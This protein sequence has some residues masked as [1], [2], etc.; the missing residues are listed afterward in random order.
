MF[1]GEGD[2][3]TDITFSHN[4]NFFLF[5]TLENARPIAKGRVPVQPSTFPV[6]TGS[7][8]A[9]MAYL[10]RPSPAG[11]FIFPDLSVRHE[12]LYRLAFS[13]FEELK[14]SKDA[15]AEPPEGSSNK[16]DE[17]LSS[18]PMAPRAHVHFRLEVKSTPFAVFSAKKFPGLSES[19]PLSRTV[20][21]QGCR[22]RIRRDVRMRR[23][24]KASDG[25]QDFDD[26]NVAY[27]HADHYGTPQQAPDRPRSISHGSMDAQTPYSTGRRPSYP[28]Y[29]YFPPNGQPANFQQPPPPAPGQSATFNNY[30]SFGV[31]AANQYATPTFQLPQVVQQP[32]QHYVQ[33]NNGFQ[34][35]PNP[36]ARQMS[37]LQ[38]YSYHQPPQQ[39]PSYTN[40]IQPQL[41]C[42]GSTYRPMSGDQRTPAAMTLNHQ[43]SMPQTMSPYSQNPPVLQQAYYTQQPQPGSRTTTPINTN[44][45]GHGPQQLS[46]LRTDNLEQQIAIEQK[47]E[48]KQEPKSPASAMQR[49]IAPSPSYS[50]SYNPFNYALSP[51][52]NPMSARNTT[53]RPFD[54]VFDNRSLQQPMY[55]GMRPSSADQG[56]DRVQIE[57][58]DGELEDLYGDDLSVKTLVYKRADGTQNAKKCLSPIDTKG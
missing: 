33:A 4:A 27:P 56:K 19:T 13:L 48:T 17:L 52:N 38:G 51:S 11:Y 46:P 6:L 35:D 32:P 54:T 31:S 14:E 41:S 24:D 20:A 8:V 7:P 21:E 34:Y 16:R 18:N 1:E 30:L 47:Y 28:E 22:V 36:H 50:S 25:Y 10:D 5:T 40:Y 57:T 55:S 9:G 29:N 53:K 42:D 43:S 39:L 58:D 12:G 44:T 2:A 15:D 49:P 45:N 26:D 23:R 3:K 37:V